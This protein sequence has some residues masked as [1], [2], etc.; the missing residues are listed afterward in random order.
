MRAGVLTR[1]RETRVGKGQGGQC[2]V[3]GSI[4][5]RAGFLVKVK[6][7]EVLVRGKGGQS[8]DKGRE[9]PEFRQGFKKRP[10]GQS[11]VRGPGVA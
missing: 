4:S 10:G 2:L 11:S 8:F 9:G 1:G 3:G 7:T 5:F 6:G